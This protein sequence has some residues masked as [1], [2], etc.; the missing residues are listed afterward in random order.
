M[1]EKW[2]TK[3]IAT[4]YSLLSEKEGN[5][6]RDIGNKTDLDQVGNGKYIL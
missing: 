1:V 6:K 5:Y 3:A 2:K 4:K